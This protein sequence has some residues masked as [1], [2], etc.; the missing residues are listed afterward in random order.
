MFQIFL[1]TALCLDAFSASFAYGVAK[2]RIPLASSAVISTVCTGVLALS[3]F[4]GSALKHLIPATVTGLIC[5]I[6]LLILGL[7]KTF[8]CFLKSVIIKNE[9]YKQPIEMKLFD[10]RFVLTVYA[11]NIKADADGSKVLSSKEA[12]YLALALSFDGFAAGFGSA[13]ADIHILQ[14]ILLSLLSNILAISLGY[15]L[16]KFLAKI[17]EF[18]LSW[19]G[20]ILLIILA[21]M[22]LK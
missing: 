11:D 20:G 16:G 6:I 12:L 22:K 21:F 2:T 5:F 9:K 4:I 15:I 17:S 19:L 8:E 10:I 3:L 7:I 14:I 18:D 13:M 1:V